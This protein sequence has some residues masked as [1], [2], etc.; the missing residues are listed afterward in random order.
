[1]K[2]RLA[3]QIPSPNVI[4]RRL[5][6]G[7]FR[8]EENM[9]QVRKLAAVA[10]LG[11]LLVAG[12]WLLSRPA[13]LQP[14]TVVRQQAMQRA[15]QSLAPAGAGPGA[16][17]PLEA[18]EATAV[19][20]DAVEPVNV[21]MSDVPAGVYDPN[22][23]YDRWLR[24]EIDLESESIVS[25]VEMEAMR[26]A[27]L[28]LPPMAENVLSLQ[29]TLQPTTL[30]SGVAFAG[31]DIS[32]CC[33]GGS[34]VPPDPELAVGRDHVILVVNV[35]FAIYSKTGAVVKAATTFASLFQNV[36]GCSGMFDPNVLYDDA[37]DRYIMGLDAAGQYYCVAVSQSGN[38]M[39]GWNLYRFPMNSGGYFFDY[40]HA[41]VGRDAIY[42]GGNMFTG[43]NGPFS[44]SRVW[45]LP[46]MAMYQNQPAAAVQRSLPVQ[47]YSTPQPLKLHGAAQGDWPADAPHYILVERDFNARDHTLF[48][49]NDP[50][51]ANTFSTVGSFNLVTATGV[52]AGMPIAVPQ[53]GAGLLQ[54]NDFRPLDFEYRNGYGW[55]AMTI[56][57]N[58][59]GG[60]VNCVRWAQINLSNA[61]VVQAGVLAS[62]GEHRFFPDLAVND[63]NDMVVGYSKSSAGMYPATWVAGRRSS[64]PPGALQ[65]EV[66][67]KAGEIAYT[68]SSNDPSPHRWG[69]YTGMTIDPDGKTFWYAGQYSK[70]TGIANRRWGIYIGS[71]EFDTCAPRILDMHTYLPLV[72]RTAQIEPPPPPPPTSIVNGDFESGPVGWTEYSSQGW[73][74][75]LP[76]SELPPGLTP[77]S[78]SWAAWLGGDHDEVAYVRQQVDISSA[79]PYLGYWYWSASQDTCGNDWA[80]V[81]INNVAV[82]SHQLCTS[83]NTGAWVPQVVNLAAYAGQSVSLEFRVDTN[84]T[85]NSN[86]FLDDVAFQTGTAAPVAAGRGPAIDLEGATRSELFRR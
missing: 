43:S 27:S 75:I 22:N 41:G 50:F 34:S 82:H 24:G 86:F 73:D 1:M 35:A 37:Y 12:A 84:A 40:P 77:R 72:L 64:D 9:L 49:W 59:G 23:Q 71:F 57:C 47:Q 29:N 4:A 17:V 79:S 20:M 68:S 28:N 52:P 25:Q 74:L 10:S 38:P 60:T 76:I 33:G 83:T 48:A 85:L 21:D 62:N 14:E 69:D 31:I 3:L 8:C 15:M 51:G 16:A 46:K 81:R 66:Q 30:K 67:F 44:H 39:G 80:Q 78:G 63:C 36:P 58:P 56:A 7:I 54:A 32:Q 42:V 55:A 70:I 5:R 26:Q 18:N 61:A 53:S 2:V 45:A 11:L 6:R 65:P 19:L 13:Q